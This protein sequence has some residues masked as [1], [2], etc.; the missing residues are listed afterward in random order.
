MSQLKRDLAQAMQTNTPALAL[1]HL[2]SSRLR[3]GEERAALQ[4]DL[5][6][7]RTMVD[8]ASEDVILEALDFLAGWCQPDLK[9]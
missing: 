6:A 3:S 9:V 2:L 4:Q 8:S 7:L 5:E 1:R